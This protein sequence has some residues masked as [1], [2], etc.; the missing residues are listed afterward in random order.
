MAEVQIRCRPNGP[1]L[2]SGPITILDHEG[3]AFTINPDKPAVSLCRCGHSASKPFCDG[4]HKT[5]GFQA[6]ELAPKPSAG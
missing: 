4:A 2:V 5:C 1:F 3:N 6:M